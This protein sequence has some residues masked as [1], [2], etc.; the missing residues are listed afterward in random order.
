MSRDR[1]PPSSVEAEMALLGAL[2][3]DREIVPLIAPIVKPSDFY[4]HVHDTIFATILALYDR[5]E[6]LDKISLASELRTRGTLEKVGGLS[7]LSQL[8]DTVQ[9]AASATYYARIV[10]EKATLRRLISAGGTIASAAFAGEDDVASAIARAESALQAAI[11]GSASLDVGAEMSA[12]LGAAWREL[13][14]AQ[15]SRVQIGLSTSIAPLDAH[16]GRLQRG[17]LVVLAGAPGSGKSML[18]WQLA[19]SCARVAPVAFFA[20][21]MGTQDTIRRAIARRSRI[22]TRRLRTGAVR[23]QEWDR[24]G[25]SL[26]DLGRLQ[27][28]I[29]DRVPRKSVRDLR[30]GLQYM[31]SQGQAAKLVVVDH[32]NFLADA[33]ISDGRSSKHD[34]LDRMYQEL[35]ALASEFDLVMLLV[36]HLNRDG[37]QGV[38]TLAHLR[39]GGNLEGHAHIAMF[40]HRPDPTHAPDRGQLIL[41]KNRDGRPGMIEMVFDAEHLE[42]RPAFEDAAELGVA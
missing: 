3:V 10:A 40:V 25:E 1:V 16:T 12:A 19:E 31:Q 26:A 15:A 14:E 18:V 23:G 34:R 30:R 38:P 29:F 42:W 32:A 9:T 11:G 41:A 21:E 20:L 22:A 36:Q 37:M 39:D 27:L 4:A 5:S 35:L 24:I 2:L 7:Y 17:E 33:V 6:P 13:S 28:R 8:M